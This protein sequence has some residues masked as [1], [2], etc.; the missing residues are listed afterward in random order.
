MEGRG[1]KDAGGRRRQGEREMRPM[2]SFLYISSRVIG[3]VRLVS[4]FP[5]LSVHLSLP[6]YFSLSF[7]LCLLSCP[8]GPGVFTHLRKDMFVHRSV[9]RSFQ[10]SPNPSVCLLRKQMNTIHTSSSPQAATPSTNTT[11]PHLLR[12]LHFL[13]TTTE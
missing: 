13:P 3:F 11:K 12:Q 6:L 2:L 4:L 9:R 1:Y 7:S 10:P 5:C 8:T